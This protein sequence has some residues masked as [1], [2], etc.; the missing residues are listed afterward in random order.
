MRRLVRA[1]VEK[2]QLLAHGDHVLVGVSG[3]ADSMCLLFLLRELAKEYKLTLSVLHV[4]HGIRGEAA[5]GDAAFVTRYCEEHALPVYV[6]YVDVPA[7]AK[8]E[9]LSVEEAGRKLR[10][11]LLAETAA[12]VGAT[13]VCVA[14]HRD[15][16]AETV[17]FRMLRGTG[18]RGLVGMEPVSRPFADESLR[19]V[20]PLLCVGREDI[21]R[22]LGEEGISFRTDESN[23]DNHYDRNYLRNVVFPELT[24]IN[25][26]AKEHLAKLSEHL[27]PVAE[28]LAELTAEALPRCITEDGLLCEPTLALPA[29]VRREVLLKYLKQ[30]AGTARD[31]TEQHIEALEGLLTAEVSKELSLPYGLTLVRGYTSI[32]EEAEKESSPSEEAERELH[33]FPTKLR[34]FDGRMLECALLKHKKSDRI[35]KNKCTKWFDYDKIIGSISVRHRRSGD[36]LVISVSGQRKSLQDVLVNEKIPKAKREAMEYVACGSEILW[37]PGC[38]GSEAYRVNDDT[39]TVLQLRLTDESDS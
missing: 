31:L 33:D 26:K 22:F 15:D 21:E 7:V 2:E 18:L 32:F 14:H 5:D 38:R 24:H 28:L 30:C 35:P 34:L 25:A 20:R 6:R 9:H 3:G 4:H 11:A 19:L 12:E 29:A 23:A 27:R 16:L 37:I 36:Y 39:E 8:Q 1:Y 13:A 10:Y 17:L